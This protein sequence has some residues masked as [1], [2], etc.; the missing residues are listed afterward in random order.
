M[1]SCTN[2]CWSSLQPL[3]LRDRWTNQET[4]GFEE[5]FFY[6][7]SSHLPVRSSF[8]PLGSGTRC[9][10]AFAEVH[11]TPNP[12]RRGKEV[13]GIAVSQLHRVSALRAKI[14]QI[15]RWPCLT[16]NVSVRQAGIGNG[17]FEGTRLSSQMLWRRLH[18]SG[19]ALVA[20]D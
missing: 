7:Q 11:G 4:V 16:S 3:L 12:G 8:K 17:P 1:A 14:R 19:Y 2:L 20:R 15:A 18:V 13:A 10:M 5:T 9:F 6:L